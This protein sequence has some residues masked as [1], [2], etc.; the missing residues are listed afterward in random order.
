MRAPVQIDA[1]FGGVEVP[2][3]Q[4]VGTGGETDRG[5]GRAQHAH[6]SDRALI[7][8]PLGRGRGLAEAGQ[9]VHREQ[10][11]RVAAGVQHGAALGDSAAHRLFHEHVLARSRG[12]QRQ[13]QMGG[14]RSGDDRD[15]HV[16][17]P[18]GRLG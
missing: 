2:L 15:L 9:L 4:L 13:R 1:A 11:A 10:N 18:E 8:Q 7:D 14:M 17:P 6:L 16:R 3:L 12:A 5:P